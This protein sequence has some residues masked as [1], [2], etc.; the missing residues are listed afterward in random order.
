MQAVVRIQCEFARRKGVPWGISESA[1]S[2]PEG[3]DN[4][5]GAFGIPELAMKHIESDA[6]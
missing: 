3:G 6:S 4:G 5:Y 2:G 1:C